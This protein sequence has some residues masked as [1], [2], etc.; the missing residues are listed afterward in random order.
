MEKSQLCLIVRAIGLNE[1]IKLLLVIAK[2][3]KQA[4][5]N[6]VEREA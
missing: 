5:I 1:T 4:K 2:E 3:M 6:R